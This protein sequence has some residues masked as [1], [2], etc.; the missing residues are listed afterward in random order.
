[1]ANIRTE[2]DPPPANRK[3]FF[4]QL[5]DC[6]F[7]HRKVGMDTERMLRFTLT[8]AVNDGDPDGPLGMRIKGCLAYRWY[9]PKTTEVILIWSPP[10]TRNG[11]HYHVNALVSPVLYERV[12]KA[13]ERSGYAPHLGPS[14]AEIEK[15]RAMHPHTVDA[16][17]PLEILAEPDAEIAP[18][19]IAASKDEMISDIV[20]SDAEEADG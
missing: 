18:E 4:W 17:L 10:K 5:S 19:D 2:I 7:V 20:M 1:M 3:K 6:K 13:I 8:W 16:N 15:L 12:K 11:K 9:N 14:D